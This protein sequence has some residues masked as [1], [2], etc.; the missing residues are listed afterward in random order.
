MAENPDGMEKTEQATPKR[1]S[2]ARERGQ[3][4][5][6][7]DVTTSAMLLLGGMSVFIFGSTISTNLLGF[8]KSLLINIA[9][10]EIT[11]SSI[12]D[13]SFKLF[14]FV[15]GIIA[16]VLLTIFGIAIAG[17]VAQVGF[18]FANK[19][20]TEGLRFKEVFNPFKGIKKVIFSKNSIFELAKG[21]AKLIVLGLIAYS[22]LENKSERIVIL[23]NQPF[24][25]VANFIF[26]TSFELIWKI[27]LAYIVIALT[28]YFYQRWR[29]NEDMKMTKQETKDEFKQMEG[30]PLIKSR[31]RSIMRSRLRQ[32]MIKNIPSAD[33]ILTNPTHFAVAIK[34]T[35]GEMSA[36][37]V[38]AKGVDFLAMKIRDIAMDNNVP[39]VE[40]PPLARQLYYNVDV[41]EEIPEELYKAVAQVLAY[42]YS[43]RQ[44]A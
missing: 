38:I 25:E 19:K 7:V 15:A 22:V 39:I 21:I 2:E 14:G 12:Q 11:D 34:Y 29:F 4:A 24:I 26:S 44:T 27:G 10:I 6:S 32:L 23:M 5:K 42:V 1:L 28:D 43:L 20:F 36:P 33:V 30:D 41:D 16:P 9:K 31:I 13:F 35:K 37:K 8:T 18:K 40:N 17:E 3:V